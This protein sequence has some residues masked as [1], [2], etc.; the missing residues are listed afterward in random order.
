MQIKRSIGSSNIP[1]DS[2]TREVPQ[3][4]PVQAG[5][6]NTSDS[7]ETAPQE[8]PLSMINT[9]IRQPSE[10]VSFDLKPKDNNLQQAFEQNLFLSTGILATPKSRN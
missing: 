5:V 6:A 1:I 3:Q 10:S 7:F 2:G 8:D 9:T 4:R